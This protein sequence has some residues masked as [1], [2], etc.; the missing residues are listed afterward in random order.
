M[1]AS[2]P[3]VKNAEPKKE[4]APRLTAKFGKFIEFGFFVVNHYNQQV[5]AADDGRTPLDADALYLALQVF[6]AVPEQQAFVQG[7]FDQSKDVKKQLRDVVKQHIK[8]NKPPVQRKPRAKK[9]PKSESDSDAAP[10]DPKPKAKRGRKPAVKAEANPDIVAEIVALAQTSEPTPAPKESVKK[11]K[12]AIKSAPETKAET[13]AETKTESKADAKAA[14]KAAKDAE[15]AAAKAA[16]DAE[17]AAS[18]ATPKTAK[19]TPPKP[20][21]P[22]PPPSNESNDDD[23]AEPLQ[24]SI[25][26]LNGTQYL[27]DDN[28]TVYDFQSQDP[29]GKFNPSNQSISR[30]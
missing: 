2:S 1:S 14:A 12:V 20:S 13:K 30:G 3:V 23:D 25:L 28:N 5:A 27:L 15:K 8:A 4:R 17:K 22:I 26:N 19:A 24:V 29:I 21:D 18:K 16:K 9:E 6:G 7:F 11:P 10:A